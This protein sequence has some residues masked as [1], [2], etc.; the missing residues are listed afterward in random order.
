MEIITLDN[1]IG[2][3][4][5]TD[6]VINSV[7]DGTDLVG[8]AYFQGVNKLIIDEK[9]LTPR[10]FDLSTKLAGEILQ[11]FSNYQIKL[12]IVGDLKKFESNSLKDFIF[13]SNKA[14]QINFVNSTLEAISALNR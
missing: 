11:K 14:G 7:E 1:G 13:E 12:A 9:Q 4:I 2:Q 3:L 10:F 8:N 6:A 5:S